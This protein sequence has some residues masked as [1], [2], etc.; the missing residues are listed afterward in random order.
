MF[1]GAL[2]TEGNGG[3]VGTQA[4]RLLVHLLVELPRL[5]EEVAPLDVAR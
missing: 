5:A 4:L 2:G 3:G 1:L